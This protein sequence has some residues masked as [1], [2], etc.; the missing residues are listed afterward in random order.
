MN[1]HKGKL[2]KQMRSWN[3]SVAEIAA[4]CGMSNR[5]VR[6][7]IGFKPYNV[8]VHYRGDWP[9]D[10]VCVLKELARM[11][12]SASQIGIKIGKTRNAIIGFCHRNGIKLM[13]KPFNRFTVKSSQADNRVSP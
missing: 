2:A 5:Q 10:K 11:G 8:G 6:D 3:W 12:Y 1:E 4:A 7:A 9:D 13:G